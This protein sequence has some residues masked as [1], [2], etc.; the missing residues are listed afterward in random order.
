M[1]TIRAFIAITLPQSIQHQLAE[2]RDTLQKEME[3]TTV[4]WVN[5][6]NIHLTLKFLGEIPEKDV[7]NII[8]KLSGEIRLHPEFQL[9]IQ[10]IGAFPS[11]QQPR[12]IWA[13]LQEADALMRLQRSI[14]SKMKELGYDTEERPFSAHVTIGRVKQ[15]VTH[16]QIV[17]CGIV[18]ARQDIGGLDGFIVE[19]VELYRSELTRGAPIYTRLHTYRL[20]PRF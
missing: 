4:R 9:N 19:S 11:V 3:E 14:E 18:V 15:H 7:T 5:P 13:G 12:V 2:I 1:K 10:G 16:Q 6:A 20:K 17:N 8:L